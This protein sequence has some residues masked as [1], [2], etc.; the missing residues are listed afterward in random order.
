MPSWPFCY[1]ILPEIQNHMYCQGVEAACS[2]AARDAP[3]AAA[4][5]SAPATCAAGAARVMKFDTA[6]W[7]MLCARRWGA[8]RLARQSNPVEWRSVFSGR[9]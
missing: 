2:G 5:A 9:I 3:A 6:G 8:Q 4:K 1:A 7:L